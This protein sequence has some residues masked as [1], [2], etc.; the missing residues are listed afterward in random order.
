M[1]RINPT[2]EAWKDCPRADECCCND[3]PLT[4]KRYFSDSSDTMPKCLFG[5]TGRLRIG[6]KW[7]LK[8]R[9]LKSRELSGVLK[10]ENMSEEE[11]ELKRTKLKQNSL[12]SQLNKKGYTMCRK[13]KI[14]AQIHGETAQNS[15]Q[16]PSVDG[17]GV[18]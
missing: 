3:C 5:K 18:L 17:A 4:I 12:I 1:A 10:W 2:N 7:G 9:G 15:A 11:R 14:K 13:K 16:E 8:N 6:K